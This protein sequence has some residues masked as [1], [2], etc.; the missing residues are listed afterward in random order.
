MFFSGEKMGALI[1]G[2]VFAAAFYC[3]VLGLEFSGISLFSPDL[4]THFGMLFFF[5]AFFN[6]INM[7]ALP[8]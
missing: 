5:L 6:E 3:I 2:L 7:V 8:R 4:F 1:S